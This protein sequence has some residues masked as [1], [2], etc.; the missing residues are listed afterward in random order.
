[1]DGNLFW[2]DDSN[3]L[4]ERTM[5]SRDGIVVVSVPINRHSGA[6]LSHPSVTS[7]GF[8]ESGDFP[9]VLEQ[10][11]DTVLLELK[12]ISENGTL[13]SSAIESKINKSVAALLFKKT[14]LRPIVISFPVLT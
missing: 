9:N 12:T 8:I 2:A 10:I 11:A 4:K 13:S 3:V 1:M 14:R 6:V 5:L 7:V